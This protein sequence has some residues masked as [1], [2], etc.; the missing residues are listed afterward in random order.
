MGRLDRWDAQ[1]QARVDA[2]NDRLGGNDWVERL[3][4]ET[5][6]P[7]WAWAMASVPILHWFGDAAIAVDAWRR[8]RQP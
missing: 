8:R 2:D 7:R 5:P 3:D 4:N 6:G 1:N